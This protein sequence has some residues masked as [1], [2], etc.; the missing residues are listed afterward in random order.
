MIRSASRGNSS[1]GGQ[2]ARRRPLLDLNDHAPVGVERAAANGHG[3]LVAREALRH[4][5]GVPIHLR[6]AVHRPATVAIGPA[7]DNARAQL[8][9]EARECRAHDRRENVRHTA[10]LGA[11]QEARVAGSLSLSD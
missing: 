2:P 1:E 6:P 5:D 7:S 9:R 3:L 11:V 4:G 8:S 10:G